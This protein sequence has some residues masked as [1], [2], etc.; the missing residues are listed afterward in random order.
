MGSLL[1]TSFLG[2]GPR[3]KRAYLLDPVTLTSGD[4]WGLQ[5]CFCGRASGSIIVEAMANRRWPVLCR[6]AC[7]LSPFSSILVSLTSGYEASTRSESEGK[8][9]YTL[10]L[11]VRLS[12]RHESEFPCRY[13]CSQKDAPIVKITHSHAE[14]VQAIKSHHGWCM[15]YSPCFLQLHTT[16]T[17]RVHRSFGILRSIRIP[18]VNLSAPLRVGRHDPVTAS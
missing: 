6:L 11:L 16:S 17:L 12:V 18:V 5:F 3:C 14:V 7:K 2:Q 8:G 1:D 13:Y 10:G 9:K 4:R 15:H